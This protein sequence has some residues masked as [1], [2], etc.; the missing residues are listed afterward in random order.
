MNAATIATVKLVQQRLP[1][2]G[3]A[4][5]ALRDALTER[6]INGSQPLPYPLQ[7]PAHAIYLGID[8]HDW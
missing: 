1:A 4:S 3:I 8:D 5:N 2:D 6:Q 7:N